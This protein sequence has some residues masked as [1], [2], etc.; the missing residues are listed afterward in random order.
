MKM[1][2]CFL[3]QPLFIS[4]HIY[5]RSIHL[6][7]GRILWKEKTGSDFDVFY[8]SECELN[9]NMMINYITFDQL[10]QIS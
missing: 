10:L 4:F 6:Q 9:E 7:Y 2:S 5:R 8:G 3:Y 1:K